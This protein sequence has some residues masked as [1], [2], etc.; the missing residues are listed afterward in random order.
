MHT[1]IYF[2]IT[3]QL[4]Q[5]VEG[6]EK[7][8]NNETIKPAEGVSKQNRKWESPIV[9]YVCVCVHMCLCVQSMHVNS[10]YGIFISE[11]KSQTN[12]KC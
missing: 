4:T 9:N 6:F 1:Q 5:P 3:F 12:K 2:E 11:D 7:K 10:N 8:K